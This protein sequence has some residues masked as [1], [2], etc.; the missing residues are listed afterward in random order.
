VGVARGA[1]WGV[2]GA[3]GG[4]GDVGGTGRGAVDSPVSAQDWGER[5]GPPCG[6][7]RGPHPDAGAAPGSGT[8]GRP[9]CAVQTPRPDGCWVKGDR[10]RG[11]H[12]DV[13][14]VPCATHRTSHA[15][16]GN[17]AHETTLP[18]TRRNY[19]PELFRAHY[20]KVESRLRVAFT[21]EE[22]APPP[23]PLHQSGPFLAPPPATHALSQRI[24]RWTN[25]GP[26]LERAPSSAALARASQRW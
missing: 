5:G 26:S 22:E 15:Q 3:H 9:D 7:T 11:S 8:R 17:F 16:N 21:R 6:A 18:I 4:A 1:A 10:R 2:C 24:S 25:Q 12:V 13:P 19:S 20:A 23:S 14:D